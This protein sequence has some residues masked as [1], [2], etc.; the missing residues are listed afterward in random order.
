[1]PD[2]EFVN[3][4]GTVESFG[5]DH[6]EVY[7]ET[8]E[9]ILDRRDVDMIFFPDQGLEPAAAVIADLALYGDVSLTGFHMSEAVSNYIREGVVVAAMLPGLAA[10]AAAGAEACGDYL[11]AG[12]YDTG[13]V[14]IDPVAVTDDNVD[15]RD[16]TLP[17]N[18]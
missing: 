16:W 13:H 3:G 5:F 2:V 14:T 15:D 6:N 17:E 7:D 4:P 12:V 18:R 1:M 10:Q 8:K 9:W 11:L